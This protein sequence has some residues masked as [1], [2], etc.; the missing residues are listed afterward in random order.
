MSL[1]GFLTLLQLAAHYLT[2]N[3]GSD[4]NFKCFNDYLLD[5]ICCVRWSP[6]GDMTASASYGATVAL[7][8]FKT[9][10]TDILERPQMKVNL[11]IFSIT[12][13]LMYILERA[14]SVCF[15]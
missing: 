13:N 14:M 9:D 8:D 11:I 1:N 15:I 10:S 4:I 3:L 5:V 6:K 12:T 7:L 2:V